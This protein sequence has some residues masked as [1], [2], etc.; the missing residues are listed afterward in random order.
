MKLSLPVAEEMTSLSRII[1]SVHYQQQE[2]EPKEIS[3]RPMFEQHTAND[4]EE[5]IQQPKVPTLEEVIA[6]RDTLLAEGQQQLAELQQQQAEQFEAQQQAFLQEQQ[7]FYDS[8]PQ[9]QQ[10][11]YDAGFQQGFE[12]GTLKAQADLA[13]SLHQANDIVVQAQHNAKAYIDAQEALILELALVSA[14][15]ILGIVLDRQDEAFVSVVA[16]ALKEAREMK[17]I[18][19]YVAPDF[20]EVVSQNRDELAE[21][22]PPDVPFLIFVNEDLQSTES[23]IE[24][25]HGRIVVSIDTQLQQLRKALSE[26]LYSKE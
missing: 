17:E 21:M 1:R 16:R 19:V 4:Y 14:E 11:G 20:Y 9:V 23:Y 10:D 5:I 13:A 25:N 12:E 18:K 15:Q 3:I 8:L 26:L 6:E 2:N 22:F 7:A 24:T